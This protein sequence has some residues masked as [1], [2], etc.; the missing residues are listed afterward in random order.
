MNRFMIAIAMAVAASFASH[1]DGQDKGRSDESLFRKSFLQ[2][3]FPLTRELFEG[4]E[5]GRGLRLTVPAMGPAPV[6]LDF[7]FPVLNEK[8]QPIQFD[9]APSDRV[10]A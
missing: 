4:V 3:A 5:S 1:A 7:T 6:T 2:T 9:T 8:E 10:M